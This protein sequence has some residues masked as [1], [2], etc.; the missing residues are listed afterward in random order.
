MSQNYV[1]S[2]VYRT[3]PSL[4]KLILCENSQSFNAADWI[5]S[6]VMNLFKFPAESV[7]TEIRKAE[8]LI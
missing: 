7:D 3:C 2:P 8:N 4:M 1:F 6:Q 5:L